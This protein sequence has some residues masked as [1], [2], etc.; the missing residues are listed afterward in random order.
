MEHSISSAEEG[1]RI[2]AGVSIWED[3]ALDAAKVSQS[4][5]EIF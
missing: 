1:E 5:A 4:T 2:R 3:V